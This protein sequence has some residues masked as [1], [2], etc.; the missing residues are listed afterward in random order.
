MQ[1]KTVKIAHSRDIDMTSNAVKLNK[2]EIFG[3]EITF[4]RDD[5]HH[6]LKLSLNRKK[7]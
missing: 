4:E 7:N 6:K 5:T 3:L 2:K 1:I